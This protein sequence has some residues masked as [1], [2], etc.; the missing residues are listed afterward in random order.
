M[1]SF[2]VAVI[3][4]GPAGTSAAYDLADAGLSVLILEKRA[5]PREKPCGGAISYSGQKF[6]RFDIPEDLVDAECFGAR[7]NTPESSITS[8]TNDRLAILV[9]R[10]NF[11][12]YLL[13]MA[14][15]KGV[16]AVY[17]MAKEIKEDSGFYHIYT[18]ANRYLA[19]NVIIATGIQSTLIK[20]VRR[21]DNKDELGIC[22]EAEIDINENSR[23]KDLKNIIEIHFGVAGYG[24]GWVFPHGNFLSIGVGGVTSVFKE[25][26]K[27]MYEFMS[28]LGFKYDRKKIRGHMIP[29]GG[30]KRLTRK[31]GLFLVGDAA[32]FVEPF[33]GEGIAYAIRSGQIA[34]NTII[35]AFK[36]SDFSEEL[37]SNYEKNCSAEIGSTM[38]Y[39]LF[40]SKM[41][42]K[43]PNLLLNKIMSNQHCVDKYLEIIS[44]KITYKD[45]IKWIFKKLPKILI[46]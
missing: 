33:T 24:Y 25:P 14:L 9:S 18:N 27:A 37:L 12:S 13:D 23:Y 31:G 6:L 5:M 16:A 26:N 35:K 40:F 39:A 1:K 43:F 30:I 4:A 36:N 17:E 11:D 20:N 21:L 44:Q 45:Y 28:K 2:D 8:I 15:N 10:K 19:K 32:G 41:L 3:G 29:K 34:A 46:G 42:H 7:I 38:G 22:L